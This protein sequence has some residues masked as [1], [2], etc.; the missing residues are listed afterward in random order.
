VDVGPAETSL[1]GYVGIDAGVSGY[2]SRVVEGRPVQFW[3]APTYGSAGGMH[4]DPLRMLE[5]AREWKRLGVKKA[6]M[7]KLTNLPPKMGGGR[8]N[9]KRGEAMGAWRVA[10]AAV[11]IQYEEA[12]SSDWKRALGITG[13]KETLKPKAI[14]KAKCLSP[15]TD[16]RDLARHPGASVP[17]SDKAESYLLG[18]YCERLDKGDVAEFEEAKRLWREQDA[19]RKREN[20]RERAKRPKKKRRKKGKKAKAGKSNNV[21][22]NKPS[23]NGW[24]EEAERS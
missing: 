9:Y 23:A 21:N 3:P 15:S 7:E 14:H 22:K 17:C 8:T 19:E 1:G 20:A 4:Y 24:R 18:W 13:P 2:S 16:F 12:D 11:D 5:Q 6:L 10:L